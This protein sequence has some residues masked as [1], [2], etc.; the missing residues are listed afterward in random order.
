[1]SWTGH[2][3]QGGRAAQVGA[4][5]AGSASSKGEHLH[6]RLRLH[7][8]SGW[9]CSS[10]ASRDKKQAGAPMARTPHPSIALRP[11]FLK[12]QS[13]DEKEALHLGGW[14]RGS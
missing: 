4:G 5:L 11:P 7:L 10:H 12:S 13:K 2:S 8:V 1:M 3:L 9:R 6:L 14:C